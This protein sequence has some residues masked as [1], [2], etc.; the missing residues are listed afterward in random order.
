MGPMR[1]GL[2]CEQR[3]GDVV[4]V[5]DLWGHATLNRQP[6][7]GWASETAAD[8]HY[9]DGL[10]AWAGDE[11]WRTRDVDPHAEPPPRTARKARKAKPPPP[12]RKPP[13]P[14]RKPPPPKPKPAPRRPPKAEKAK[15]KAK[16]KAKEAARE[17]PPKG[18][19]PLKVRL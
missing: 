7:I 4:I 2:R 13:P 10:G 5:P 11:W 12:P 18:E 14:P 16:A 6:S 19:G 8:R 1:R 15:G 9:D 17:W 3:A